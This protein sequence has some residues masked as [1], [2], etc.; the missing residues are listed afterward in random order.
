MAQTSTATANFNNMLRPLIAA[1][2]EDLLRQGLPHLLPGNF[3]HATHVAGS[4]GTMRYTNIPDIVVDDTELAAS[5]VVTEGLPNAAAA[6]AF[7]NEEFATRQR[8][9]TLSFTD[10]ALLESPQKLL[11]VGANRLARYVLELGERIAANKIGAGTNVFR[12]GGQGTQAA[13]LPT[14][15]LTGS[16]VKQAVA[17]LKAANVPTFDDGYYRSIINPLV[18][19]DFMLDTSV[20]G[21]IDASRYA[22]SAQLFESEIGRYAGVRFMSSSAAFKT[23]A[24]VGPVI[25]GAGAAIIAATDTFTSTNPHLLLTGNRVKVVSIT[26]GAGL[27][28]GTTYFAIVTGANTFKF[29]TTLANAKAGTAIDVTTDSSAQ[30]TTYI[31]DIFST[32]VFGPN[33]F[34]VGDWAN[35]ETFLTPPGGHDDPGHQ[36]ALLTWKGWMDAAV[37][38][39]MTNI[40][41]VVS[42]SR[43]IRIESA[44]SLV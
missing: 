19:L 20:G 8:M 1:N 7:G 3:I 24:V 28:A 38:G 26:G 41:G 5:L 32:T 27:V 17:R 15:V 34:A 6:L 36:S 4:T 10:V 11:V 12:S 44:A 42:P 39:E 30:S 40:A 14:N 13:L 22:G 23:A 33:F 16:D 25:A 9:K 37:I 2:L 21:W 31:S 18:Q 35:N 43:Y 29:A